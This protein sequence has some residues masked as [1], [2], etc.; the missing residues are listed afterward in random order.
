MIPEK[1]LE[2]LKHEG[3]VAIV[4]QGDT[5]H[6][7]N[8]SNSYLTV[9]KDGHL[10]IPAGR[11]KQTEENV[12]MNPQVLL[13]AGSREIPGFQ[14]MGTGFLVVGTAVFL[15]EGP[16]FEVTKE[17]FPWIRAVLRITPK[18]INQTL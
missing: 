13:T 4:S 18:T 10:L 12:K 16:D 11:M 9:T 6:V 7:V 5:A 15:D 2:V 17:R 8:S 3:V 1:F 14:S